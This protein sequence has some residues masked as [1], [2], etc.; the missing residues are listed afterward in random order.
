MGD[1]F[2][3][4]DILCSIESDKTTID[5]EMQEEGYLAAILYPDGTQDLPVGQ[6]IAVMC[7]EE[8]EI[9]NFKDCKADDFEATSSVSAS[10]GE[11]KE[12]KSEQEAAP[13]PTE[14]V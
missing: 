3:P 4:G 13:T 11:S 7:E 1:K 14:S 5:F 2:S 6:V 12:A 10:P 8:D 9:A